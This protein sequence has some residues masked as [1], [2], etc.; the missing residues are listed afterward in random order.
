MR[1]YTAILILDKKYCIIDTV[2]FFFL[3]LGYAK[4]YIQLQK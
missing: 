3:K 4:M 1:Y 2:F